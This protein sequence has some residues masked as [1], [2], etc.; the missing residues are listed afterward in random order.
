MKRVLSSFVLGLAVLIYCSDI[1]AQT[2]TGKVSQQM[3]NFNWMVGDWSGEAWYLGRDQKKTTIVQNEHII[4]RLDGALITMEGS[5]YDKPIGADN[6]KL[7]FQ[8]FGI[9]TY[10]ISGSKFVLRAYQGENFTDSDLVSNPN[11]SYTWSFEA[12]YGKTRYTITH[13]AE[14]KWNE[15]GEQSRDGITWNQFFEMTLSKL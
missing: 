12:S 3:K 4:T 11:G 8:A 6:A 10:D 1:H 5:G 13:T 15:R 7:V 9:L 14:G 2:A